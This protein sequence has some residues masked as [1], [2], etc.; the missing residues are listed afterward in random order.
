[1]ATG[2][3]LGTFKFMFAHWAVYGMGQL[4]GYNTSFFE[5]FLSVEA[6]ALSCMTIFY[7]FSGYIMKS[8][9][10]RRERKYRE[11]IAAGKTPKKKKVFTRI[12]KTI[13]W[14]RM[15][16]GIVGVTFIAPLVMSIPLGSV[17]CAKFYRNKKWTFPL[18]VLFTLIYSTIMCVLIK[19]S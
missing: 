4:E 13:V 17:V 7:W 2:F 18:M 5:I 14:V 9:T 8:V 15:K 19:F 1:M 6:G 10:D 16:F 3:V 11:A 12:N